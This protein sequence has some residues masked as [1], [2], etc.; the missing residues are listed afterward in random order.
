MQS[1]SLFVRG[2]S[3]RIQSIVDD[4]KAWNTTTSPN[5]EEI[6]TLASKAVPFEHCAKPDRPFLVAGAD[7]S[8]DFPC[9]T[10][11]DSFVYYVTAKARIYKADTDAI[12]LVELPFEHSE[13]RDLL[14]LP[15]DKSKARTCYD[16]FF[17]RLL[18]ESLEKVCSES[19]YFDLKRHHH[20]APATKLDLIETLLRPEAHDA[21]NIRVQLLPTAEIATNLAVLASNVVKER[22]DVAT[23]LFQDGTLALP[24][25]HKPVSL[26]FEIARRLVCVRA[27]SQGVCYLALSKSHDMPQMD[28]IE[29]AIRERIPTLEHWFLRIPTDP[30][31]GFIGTR[32][33]PPTGAVTYLFRLHRTTPTM[34]L[35]LDSRYWQ[36]F[37]W[38]ED[39]SVLRTR[40]IQMFRDLDFASH[41]QRCYGYPY[42][43]KAS[44]DIASLTEA[45][46]VAFR[47]KVID[48]A[49]ANGL[50]RKNFL[51]PSIPAGHK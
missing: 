12:S 29:D 48:T 46:R 34:R 5:A 15:E 30:R 47:K 51:D 7:G 27:R 38:N 41:D 8:G 50:K 42:P 23:Y 11:G 32:A 3:D 19:D 39:E 17:A 33:I 40:E 21:S 16:S 36:S 4:L 1:D 13:V 31:P 25:V 49:V 43:I 35:D 44:H 2:L 26:L 18:G 45:E 24:Q 22:G 9:V 10:Y 6:K 37:L 28:K 14:W 20:T